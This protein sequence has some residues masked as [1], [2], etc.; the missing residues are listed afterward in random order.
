MDRMG[1]DL[2]LIWVDRT[3]PL[4]EKVIKLGHSNSGT[5]RPDSGRKSDD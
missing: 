5:L 4:L 1:L 3:S 2:E